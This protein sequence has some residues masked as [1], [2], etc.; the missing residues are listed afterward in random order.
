[1]ISPIFHVFR[2]LLFIYHEKWFISL[3]PVD[4]RW[5]YYLGLNS[6]QR[7]LFNEQVARRAFSS[8]AM[9]ERC[10]WV[11]IQSLGFHDLGGVPKSWGYAI[12]SISQPTSDNHWCEAS[13]NCFNVGICCLYQQAV[14]PPTR[15][16][17]HC[18]IITVLE[19]ANHGRMCYQQYSNSRILELRILWFCWIDNPQSVFFARCCV[20]Q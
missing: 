20:L 3:S 18:L 5:G 13:T 17:F 15:R 7:T 4:G 9:E 10:L 12:A 19:P 14:G 16:V 11:N 1:M 8:L 6:H 2:G